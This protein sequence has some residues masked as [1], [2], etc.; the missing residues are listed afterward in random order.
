M[1][2]NCMSA[3]RRGCEIYRRHKSRLYVRA[4]GNRV[5]C[6]RAPR[7]ITGQYTECVLYARASRRVNVLICIIC[8]DRIMGQCINAYYV[9]ILEACQSMEIL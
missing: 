3:D 5:A 7:R 8:A 6:A 9:Y 4:Y 2:I 1:A